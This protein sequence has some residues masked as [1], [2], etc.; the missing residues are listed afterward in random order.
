MT[1]KPTHM[2]TSFPCFGCGS[3]GLIEANSGLITDG[4]GNES[5]KHCVWML[6]P[7]HGLPLWE[8]LGYY[9]V[10]A[11]N[12]SVQVYTCK[13]YECANSQLLGSLPALF[14]TFFSLD[15]SDYTTLSLS[16]NVPIA[17]VI[18]TSDSKVDRPGFTLQWSTV[19]C[20]Q[21]PVSR[22]RSRSRSRT[23]Y[24][25][26]LFLSLVPLEF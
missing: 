18:F 2:Q 17:Q 19:S 12:G 7:P 25:Q 20:Q 14:E 16:P 9:N 1:L 13:E 6:A 24:F 11:N 3:C 8:I 22:S 23:I 15:Q 26:F 21:M 10:V 4:P 5:S